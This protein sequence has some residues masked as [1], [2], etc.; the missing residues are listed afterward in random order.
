MSGTDDAEA[1]GVE[2]SPGDVTELSQWVRDDLRVGEA[3]LASAISSLRECVLAW[4]GY[5]LELATFL[6]VSVNESTA[7]SYLLARGAMPINELAGLLGFGSGSATLLVD[8]LE[9]KGLLQ[10]RADPGDRRRTI[11]EA[12]ST[13][14]RQLG[15]MLSWPAVVFRGLEADEVREYA[16]VLDAVGDRLRGFARLVAGATAPVAPPKRRQ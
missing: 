2:A 8:R 1:P 13:T 6:G 14:H 12:S 7:L 3:E 11:V 9:A 16:R 15:E 10:R 4:E 5:R